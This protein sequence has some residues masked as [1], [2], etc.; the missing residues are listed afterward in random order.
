[1]RFPPSD[2]AW[3]SS[4]AVAIAS[5]VQTLAF[6]ARRGTRPA[7]SRCPTCLESRSSA[8]TCSPGRRRTP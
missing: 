1:V 3:C 8:M 6:R 2:H 5:L 4:K 7:W